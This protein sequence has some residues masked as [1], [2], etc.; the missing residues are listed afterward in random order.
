[1]DSATHATLA[2]NGGTPVRTS[3]FPTASDRSG[4]RLGEEE[5]EACARVIASGRLNS[6]VGTETGQLEAEFG[7]YYNVPH[8]VA[9]SSGT[10][11]LHLAVAAVN[12]EPGDEIITT[13][14][15][16]VGTVVPVLFQNAVPVFAD[17]DPLTGNLDFKAVETL[18][19]SR[20]RAIMAVHLFGAPAPV[21]ELRAL[22]DKHGLVLIEDCAQ[23]YLTR[24]TDDSLAGT[25]GHL[26][27]F[28]LQQSKHIT[29]G[30]GGL[31]VTQD[32]KLAD[33]MRLFADK[34]WPRAG[35]DRSHL[36]L[37]ANYRMTELAGAVARA[38]LP[39][40]ADVARARRRSAR[41]LS[42]VIRDL[43]GLFAAPSGDACSYWQF[44]II[45]DQS[46]AGADAH[47]Y[48]KALRAEGIPAQ[49][50]YLARPLY[51]NPLFTN[52]RT[53]GGSAFPFTAPPARV[54]HTYGRGL[55]PNAES[56]INERLL[57]LPWNEEYTDEDVD[58]IA[59]ALRKV[60]AHFR[61]RRAS[62]QRR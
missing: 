20:T 15:S 14:I 39:K 33:H 23:A 59:Q 9:S 25:V 45:F 47:E 17:V 55:C 11:A 32:S 29:A 41:R 38:Q 58:D 53:Y 44:P 61:G 52:R 37:A 28:S 49:P 5:L 51:L 30:D 22:A 34:G 2:V 54:E 31:T 24:C 46:V 3:A 8:V 16:D 60:H 50:G 21:V 42:S 56:L 26:G 36:F 19:T 13:P 12:P 27:C 6:T 1:M 35:G 7:A 57:V 62:A 18:I 43:E 10:A 40:L 4:R 48:S